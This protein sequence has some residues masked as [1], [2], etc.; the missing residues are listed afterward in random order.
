ML[1]LSL[2]EATAAELRAQGL[3]SLRKPTASQ[4]RRLH[5][6]ACGE[7]SLRDGETIRSTLRRWT[8]G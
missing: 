6:A 4:L 7:T 3:P 8:R 1:I 2:R 5:E